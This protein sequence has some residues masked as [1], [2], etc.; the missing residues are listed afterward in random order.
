MHPVFRRLFVVP[1]SLALCVALAHGQST[2]PAGGNETA[3]AG[4]PDSPSALFAQAQAPQ[5]PPSLAPSSPAASSETDT[6][7]Q[8]REQREEAEREVKA[9]EKQRIGGI[10]PNFNVVLNGHAAPL[11]AS[12][13]F[14]IAFH[15][16]IDPAT[17]GLAFLAGGYGEL[18]DDHTGYGHGAA[19]YFKR[20][21]AAYADNADG[22]LIGNAIL[23]S[24]LHQ[25]PRYYRKGEGTIKSR[26]V[27][28]ALA[29]FICHGDNGR[30]Q[31]NVSNV[32]GNFI[33]GA[34]SNAYYPSNER[35]LGLTVENASI[36]TVEGVFGSEWLEFSPDLVG[37]VQRKRQAKR[38]R[39][40]AAATSAAT[41]GAGSPQ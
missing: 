37:Y 18:T 41:A 30:R 21:G 5:A 1:C 12:E 17:F 27:Y 9:E 6:E 3:A 20:V 11:S 34:I 7:R 32:L 13:K 4:L 39:K 10:L 35:G 40:A 24:L 25:D 29:T 31:F 16:V 19:G 2:P 33:A 23:P 14:N 22:T 15:S 38:D 28:A 8:A 36:V 26:V